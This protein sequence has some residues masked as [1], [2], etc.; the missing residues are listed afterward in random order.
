[1]CGWGAGGPV[2][3]VVGVGAVHAHDDEDVL[4]VRADRLR[5]EGKRTRLLED[6]RHD[7]V[8]DVP[9]PQQL[10][11]SGRASQSYTQASGKH[12]LNF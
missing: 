12:K 10:A 1:M 2:L 5:R 7:V 4:E 11:E 6:D 3:D 8:A 9:L